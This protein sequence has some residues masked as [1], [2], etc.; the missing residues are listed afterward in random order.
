MP[1]PELRRPGEGAFALGG[2]CPPWLGRPAFHISDRRDE[3]IEKARV[4]TGLCHKVESVI[5]LIRILSLQVIGSVE[6]KESKV[7]CDGLADV[8]DILQGL[9]FTVAGG[10]HQATD[11]TGVLNCPLTCGRSD[12]LPWSPGPEGRGEGTAGR[13][14]GGRG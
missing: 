5:H 8:G 9:E 11:H 3:D 12:V 6:S 14:I 4:V 10:C 7:G 2:E 13:R 1:F